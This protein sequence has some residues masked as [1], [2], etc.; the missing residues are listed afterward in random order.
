MNFKLLL[1]DYIKANASNQRLMQYPVF[2]IDYLQVLPPGMINDRLS[3]SMPLPVPD[4]KMAE[5]IFQ[6]QP[7]IYRSKHFT[8]TSISVE[9]EKAIQ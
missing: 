6:Y 8:G 3:H 4:R 1:E 7:H 2:N 9:A 5:L